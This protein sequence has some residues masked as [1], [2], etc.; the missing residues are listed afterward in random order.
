MRF[1]FLLFLGDH[2]TFFYALRNG[3]RQQ[4]RWPTETFFFLQKKLLLLLLSPSCCSCC[5]ILLVWRPFFIVEEGRANLFQYHGVEVGWEVT[6]PTPRGQ[7]RKGGMTLRNDL[8]GYR[9]FLEEKKV[10]G[11]CAKLVHFLCV[12]GGRDTNGF[13]PP[14]PPPKLM[15]PTRGNKK[16]VDKQYQQKKHT[17]TLSCLLWWDDQMEMR[18]CFHHKKTSSTHLSYG[19]YFV[20]ASN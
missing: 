4:H 3:A 13:P 9:L 10:F 11:P 15:L 17:H 1:L 14:P 16:V 2:S 7:G 12:R 6:Q 8:C 20:A 18:G 19:R 5:I